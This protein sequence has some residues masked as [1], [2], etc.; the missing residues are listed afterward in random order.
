[1]ISSNLIS[2]L[3]AAISFCSKTDQSFFNIVYAKNPNQSTLGVR[4]GTVPLKV[5]FKFT[6]QL[7]FCILPNRNKK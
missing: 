2:L 5:P 1:M 4:T 7:R 3:T 6:I